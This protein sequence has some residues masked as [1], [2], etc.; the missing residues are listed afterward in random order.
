[1]MHVLNSPNFHI[2]LYQYLWS[3]FSKKI[4]TNPYNYLEALF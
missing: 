4:L 2:L 3:E 1:M